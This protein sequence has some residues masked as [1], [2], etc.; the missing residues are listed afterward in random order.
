MG[1]KH[2]VGGGLYTEGNAVGIWADAEKR[3][4]KR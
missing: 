3:K 1:L 4:A 2:E